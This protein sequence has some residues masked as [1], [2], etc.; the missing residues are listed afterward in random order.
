MGLSSRPARLN[1]HSTS[2]TWPEAH[3]AL[4][5][6]LHRS[7]QMTDRR[8]PKSPRPK[9]AQHKATARC[10]LCGKTGPLTRTECCGNWICD[11][12][13]SYQVFSFARNSCAR[14]HQ[15]FTLCGFH[16]AEGH[17]GS[18]QECA[19]CRKQFETEMY[20]YYGTNEYNFTVLADP[21]R[22][23]PT[24]C[25]TCGV[26]IVLGDGGYSS[27]KGEYFCG[28]CSDERFRRSARART[29][30]RR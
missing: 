2:R 3:S 27:F 29:P 21:P 22:Y 18:W 14:N 25:A 17:T 30:K 12:E 24:L 26:R 16:G 9:S 8:P 4:T 1:R 6:E 15:R 28:K 19:E 23:T 20:V 13:A 10:G 5:C 7:L 11:D